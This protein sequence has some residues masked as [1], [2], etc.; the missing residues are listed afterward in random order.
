MLSLKLLKLL[1]LRAI[2]LAEQPFLLSLLFI[3]VR[4]LGVVVLCV[5]K[6]LGC[7]AACGIAKREFSKIHAK[8]FL[9]GRLGVRSV[10]VCSLLLHRL[11]SLAFLAGVSVDMYLSEQNAYL[12]SSYPVRDLFEESRN[13][14]KFL[15][16]L[17]DLVGRPVLLFRGDFCP[18]I[19][20]GTAK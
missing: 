9:D 2:R 15:Q 10:R 5:L 4:E 18:F 1:L 11:C 14:F 19:F 16:L 13:S 7:S 6:L 12:R 8:R 3:P 17:E 20:N